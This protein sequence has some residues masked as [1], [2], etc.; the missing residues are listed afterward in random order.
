MPL[1]KGEPIEIVD[2]DSS[3][4]VIFN[5]LRGI[6]QEHLGDLALSIEHVGSTAVPGLSAKPIIDIDVVI[7]SV[8]F[9]PEVV[10]FLSKLGYRHE[11]DL[12]IEGREAFTREGVDVPFDSQSKNWIDHHLYV[13]SKDN[14]ELARHILFRDYLRKNSETAR[15]YS[16]LKREL[17]QRF[18]NQRVAYCEGKTE[19]VSRIIN[20]AD[21]SSC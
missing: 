4:S 21:E 17:A 12:G 16:N 15:E 11:G 6:L 19:F 9:L 5:Q 20:L 10:G 2:Y 3:W 7:E 14:E 8:E 1:K 18:K 13:C